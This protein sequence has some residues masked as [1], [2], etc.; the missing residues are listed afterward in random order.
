[1][2]LR[3]AQAAAQPAL[4]ARLLRRGAA[5][6]ARAALTA[7]APDAAPDRDCW[8]GLTAHATTRGGDGDDRDA[9]AAADADA[10]EAL[11]ALRPPRVH[12]SAHVQP[13]ATLAPVRRSIGRRTGLPAA[14]VLTC[15]AP[16]PAAAPQG[17]VVGPHAFVSAGAV[18][19]TGCVLGAGAKVL[20]DAQLGAHC[21]L[22]AGAVVGTPGPGATR[23]GA[24]NVVGHYA[25]VGAQC[26][27]LKFRGGATHIE[28][29]DRNDIRE[30]ATLH[31][32][33]G[34]ARRT[35][36]GSRNLLMGGCH[37]GHDAA[38][39]S[40][41][42]LSN[43]VLLGGHT[44]VADGAVLGG[45]AAAQQHVRIGR[46]AFVAGGAMLEADVPDCMRAKGDRAELQ[47]VNS[48]GL[49]RAGWPPAAIAAAAR[50][51]AALYRG[52]PEGAGPATHA[53]L[54]VRAAH[55]LAAPHGEFAALAAAADA[56]GAPAPP[57][58]LL[59]RSVRELASR[60][61]GHGP[62]AW[63]AN[64]HGRVAALEAALAELRAELRLAQR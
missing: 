12:A 63:R 43:G 59:L 5:H 14:C 21:R 48:E 22:R 8:A 38:V 3:A 64:L 33:S 42:I 55:L 25:V 36:L 23:L 58:V 16:P 44:V 39:G 18:L 15:V 47:G 40:R 62:A 31:R 49:R 35:T 61:A 28:L 56:A 50:A 53:A 20:G 30:H 11:A 2:A 24:R 1:M 34:G 45:G 6:D 26:P 10:A 41:V 27:D 37:V 54:A 32:S 19:G 29:G 51:A 60:G 46:W 57:A 52:A 4:Y 17:V 9:G 13:G 7:A